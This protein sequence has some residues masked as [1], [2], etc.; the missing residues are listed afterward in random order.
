VVSQIGF[1]AANQ[2]VHDTDA[3]A[4][5]EQAIDHMAADEAGTACNN[6]DGA[7]GHVAPIRF[8]VR[9]L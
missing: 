9:T 4:A 6:C 3:K 1:P 2:I 7:S 5:L 8:I